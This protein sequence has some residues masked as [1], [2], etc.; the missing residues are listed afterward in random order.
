MFMAL[1]AFGSERHLHYTQTRVL[2]L[3]LDQIRCLSLQDQKLLEGSGVVTFLRVLAIDLKFFCRSELIHE[4]TTVTTRAVVDG[5]VFH[6]MFAFHP[7]VADRTLLSMNG[8]TQL[9]AENS[10]FAP[11]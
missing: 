4:L 1:T 8:L 5:D 3:P 11:K 6:T 2:H 10:M 9:N 7:S